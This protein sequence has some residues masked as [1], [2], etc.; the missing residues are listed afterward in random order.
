[1]LDLVWCMYMLEPI[2]GQHENGFLIA[3]VDFMER[4]H[5]AYPF[6]ELIYDGFNLDTVDEAFAYAANSGAYRVGVKTES[7][8]AAV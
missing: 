6:E 5:A 7:A 1:M 3:A 2:R 8:K 4:N